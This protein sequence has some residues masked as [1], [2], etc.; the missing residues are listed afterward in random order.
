MDDLSYHLDLF[1]EEKGGDLRHRRQLYANGFTNL[2]KTI[3]G[4]H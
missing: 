1:H 3:T 4:L 2:T